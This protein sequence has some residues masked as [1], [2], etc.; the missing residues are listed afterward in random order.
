MNEYVTSSLTCS[1]AMPCYTR[2]PAKSQFHFHIWWIDL[3][4][5]ERKLSER[6]TK[7]FSSYSVFCCSLWFSININWIFFLCEMEWNALSQQKPRRVC[8]DAKLKQKEKI[9]VFTSYWSNV[10]WILNHS[11]GRGREQATYS[12][13]K[14][15]N[16]I[17]TKEEMRKRKWENYLICFVLIQLNEMNGIMKKDISYFA[18]QSVKI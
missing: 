10:F 6:K 9:D 11:A 8:L 14:V 4:S 3:I 16:S 5:Y 12:F 15:E 13:A 7:G 2:H 17:S 1:P 18:I